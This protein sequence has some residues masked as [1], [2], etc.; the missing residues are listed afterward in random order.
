ML[1]ILSLNAALLFCSTYSASSGVLSRKSWPLACMSAFEEAIRWVES[2]DV[3]GPT[4]A[5]AI[6]LHPWDQHDVGAFNLLILPDVW[7]L[8]A[9]VVDHD[10]LCPVRR[11]DAGCF[12]TSTHPAGDSPTYNISP[13]SRAVAR[14]NGRRVLISQGIQLPFDQEQNAYG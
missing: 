1:A 9:G 10:T 6:S 14:V 12:E 8:C 2:T 7:H 11:G 5:L 4:T 13:S 3:D